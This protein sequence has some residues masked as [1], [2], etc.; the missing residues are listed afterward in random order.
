MVHTGGAMRRRM[1]H[2]RGWRAQLMRLT[3]DNLACRRGGRMVFTGV[4]FAVAAGEALLVTGR[5]GAGKSTLLRLLAGLLPVAAGRVGWDGGAPDQSVGE[6]AHYVGHLDA[7]KP[8]LS[9]RDNLAFWTAWNGAQAEGIDAALA[10]LALDGLA[11]LPAAYLS[12]GQR[13]RLALAR[14]VAVHRPIWLLDEPTSALDTEA[15]QVFG[16]LLGQHLAS[17]GSAIVATHRPLPIEAAMVL[18]LGAGGIA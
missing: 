18:R 10:A 12:A 8:G 14:L 3:S 15:E 6:Q 13:R 1:D 11:D 2:M 9:V 17:G 16:A 7:L 5:N 4:S